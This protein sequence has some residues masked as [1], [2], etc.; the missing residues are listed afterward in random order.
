M[1]RL[2]MIDPATAS[3]PAK[4]LL[5]AVERQFGMTPNLMRVLASAPSALRGYLT[6]S[7]ALAEGQLAPP[8]R[9]AIGLAV[10][11]R[12]SCDYCV[13]ARTVLGKGAGLTEA[14][15]TSARAGQASDARDAAAIAF[16]VQVL[17][18]QGR[19]DDADLARVRAAG[20]D[21]GAIVEIV[22]HVALNVLSN[23]V[24]HVADTANDFPPAGRMR[25]AS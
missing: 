1:T 13:S 22:A 19:V 23:Y 16:A 25:A 5:A 11:E 7:G 18:S 24:N 20:F 9:E 8:L 17:E 2:S 4:A 3:E 15:I 14:D 12:N 6:F 21:D 10:G